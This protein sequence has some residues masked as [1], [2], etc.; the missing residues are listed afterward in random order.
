MIATEGT[1]IQSF[2]ASSENRIQI[3]QTYTV[4]RPDGT[5]HEA[6]IIQAREIGDKAKEYYIHYSGLN[7]RLDQ[8]VSADQIQSS[9]SIDDDDN[10]SGDSKSKYSIQ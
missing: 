7:R 3:G 1:N 8:W 10:T 5:F 2:A 6:T 9:N 4:R